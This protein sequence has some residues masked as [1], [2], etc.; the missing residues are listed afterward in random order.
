MFTVYIHKNK[1]NGKMYVGITS[2]TPEER[3]K[4]GL[5]YKQ[6]RFRLAIDKY[7]WDNFDHIIISSCLCEKE[8]K[9]FETRLIN[10]LKTYDRNFGYNDTYGGEHNTPTE[11]VKHKI[12]EKMK[13]RFS[14]AKNPFYGKKHSDEVRARLSEIAKQRF[15]DPKNNSFYG[16]HHTDET[17]RIISEKR[18]GFV[19]SEEH[20]QKLILA[21]I[22]RHCSEEH[23]EKLRKL[24]KGVKKPEIS[25]ENN[26]KSIKIVCCETGIIYPCISQARREYG[27]YVRGI[28]NGRL[29]VKGKELHWLR[30]DKY[31]SMTE[32]E[33][34]NYMNSY[35]EKKHQ[36]VGD[37]QQ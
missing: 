14:G 17:K 4:N 24:K 18:K 11:E 20:K 5:G 23:K 28:L 7:G 12:S 6:N 27:E 8:A 25:G 36:K 22:G 13:G 35:K 10:V 34:K 37:E 9:C 21:N 33:V 29:P 1:V 2:R 3:W 19:L 30:Y 26:V 15:A 16:H 31:E 32:E